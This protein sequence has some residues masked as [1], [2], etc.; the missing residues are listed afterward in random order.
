M[1]DIVDEYLAAVAQASEVVRDPERDLEEVIGR[2]HAIADQ[3]DKAQSK[4]G[5]H[6]AGL[7]RDTIELLE[8]L[9]SERSAG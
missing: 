3:A 2:L 8:L 4:I 5:A 9:A 1:G 7:S 6:V